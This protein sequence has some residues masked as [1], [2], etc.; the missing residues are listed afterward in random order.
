MSSGTGTHEDARDANAR[1]REDR[2]AGPVRDEDAFDVAVLDSW[3]RDRTQL[4]DSSL[5][6]VMQFGGGV[7]NLTYLLRY[8][9]RDLVLRRPPTGQKAAGAHDMQREYDIQRMLAPSFPAVPQMVGYEAD[10][11]I[12]GSPFYVMAH[13]PGLILRG[14]LPPGVELKPRE[15]HELALG[16][17]D[18]LADLHS[19]DIRASGL[20]T[21]WRGPGYVA[22]QVSGWSQRYRAALTDDVPDGEVVMSWLADNQPAD[23]ADRLIHGDW[24][25]DNLVLDPDNLSIVRAVLDWEM[26]TVG[27]PLMDLGAALAYWVQAD[28]DPIF[29]MFRRQPSDLPGMP[30]REEIVAHYL[31]RTG[32]ALPEV[33]WQFYEVFGLFRLAVIAQQIWFRYRAGQT[34]NPAFAQF[35]AAVNYLVTRARGIIAR[36]G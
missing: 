4:P 29:V 19:V 7:S 17:I 13:V 27:D 28:D 23:V 18:A 24:R 2:G 5:P 15:A 16:M 34:T 12:L 3:L 1:T 21:F 10:E 14:D 31:D 35:G 8:P 9:E 22:R 32:L 25:F 36:A 11:S 20:D 6:E 26:A 30:T 33:G